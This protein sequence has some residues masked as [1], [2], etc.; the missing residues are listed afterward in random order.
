MNSQ[1]EIAQIRAA[2][3]LEIAA[4]QQAMNGFAAVGRHETIAHHFE[5]LGVIFENLST[6]VG[7]QVAIEEIVA[8]LE[9]S[10]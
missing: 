10:L 8:R 5:N 9:Q 1:S 4:M 7:E 3:D 2:I 6:Q